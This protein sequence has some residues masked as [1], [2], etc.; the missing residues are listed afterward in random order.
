LLWRYEQLSRRRLND[1]HFYEVMSGIHSSIQV[2][3]AMS[4][5]AAAGGGDRND[6]AILNNPFTRGLARL[7]GFEMQGVDGLDVFT[8]KAARQDS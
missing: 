4:M 5:M 6:A 8:G 7:I 1:V 3:R 2:V